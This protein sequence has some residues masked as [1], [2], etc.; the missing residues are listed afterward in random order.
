MELLRAERRQEAS[1]VL[2]GILARD[3]ADERAWDLLSYVQ[4]NP[5]RQAYA[6]R[7]VVRI[8][9]QNA[10]SWARLVEIARLMAAPAAAPGFE[11]SAGLEPATEDSEPPADPSQP[12][13]WRPG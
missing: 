8:N 1:A 11:S 13:D 4:T 9:P 3:P 5:A 6:L 12:A 2:A 7:Q 10:A